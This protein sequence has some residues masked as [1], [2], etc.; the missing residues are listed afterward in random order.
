MLQWKA[1]V[2]MKIHITVSE[3]LSMSHFLFMLR[4]QKTSGISL[5]KVDHVFE[6]LLQI[7]N[8]LL[9]ASHKVENMM[10]QEFVLL[11]T[12][13]PENFKLKYNP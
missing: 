6:S 7:L 9:R 13:I 10:T 11:H 8:A 1:V 4:S 12:I 5:N 2:L 3:K